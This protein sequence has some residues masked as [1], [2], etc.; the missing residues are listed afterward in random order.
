MIIQET[1]EELMI[2]IN[3][4]RHLMISTGLQKGLNDYET[5]KYSEE[6]DKLINK[7]QLVTWPCHPKTT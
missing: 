6:L 4:V 5:L 7:Y 1:L 2:Q 3:T